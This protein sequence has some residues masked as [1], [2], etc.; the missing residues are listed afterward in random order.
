M[1]MIFLL[2]LAYAILSSDGIFCVL[3]SYIT[4][5]FASYINLSSYRILQMSFAHFFLRIHNDFKVR[6]RIRQI[7]KT[8]KMTSKE[9]Y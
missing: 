2:F 9:F 3:G 5:T 6:I 1:G 4:S 7:S 8:I